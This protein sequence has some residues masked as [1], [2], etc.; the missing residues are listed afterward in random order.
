MRP[1][2]HR[3]YK[4]IF[5]MM[6]NQCRRVVV[7][8]ENGELAGMLSMRMLSLR[9]PSVRMPSVRDFFRLQ[10][11]EAGVVSGQIIKASTAEKPCET[12]KTPSLNRSS[13]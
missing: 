11:Y 1:V 12:S 9:M 4:T 7:V 2:R 10:G 3:R 5:L 13:T 8:W 6:K